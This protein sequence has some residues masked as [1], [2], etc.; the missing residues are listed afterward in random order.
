[1]SCASLTTLSNLCCM[2]NLK[3]Q[4]GMSNVLKQPGSSPCQHALGP[5]GGLA[6]GAGKRRR[7]RCSC[8][9]AS[10]PLQQIGSNLPLLWHLFAPAET[11]APEAG[12]GELCKFLVLVMHSDGRNACL[13]TAI[14]LA[15]SKGCYLQKALCGCVDGG[16]LCVSL[17][18]GRPRLEPVQVL[19]VVRLC[20]WQLLLRGFDDAKGSLLQL[21]RCQCL[22]CGWLQIALSRRNRNCHG[23]LT[24]LVQR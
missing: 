11:S 23:R 7:G 20:L 22:H 19:L 12:L 2:G 8:R 5:P 9:Q 17:S 21:A 6:P 4:G 15:G 1:M 24:E 16:P 3:I 10:D 13:H 14:C 18:D